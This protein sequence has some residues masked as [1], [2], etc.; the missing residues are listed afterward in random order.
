MKLSSDGI[1]SYAAGVGTDCPPSDSQ[2]ARC[3]RVF[4][5]AGC[6]IELVAFFSAVT[7]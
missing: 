4:G 1:L 7:P 3:S 5:V 2:G 6:D